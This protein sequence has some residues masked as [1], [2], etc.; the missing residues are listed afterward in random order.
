METGV[1]AI[2]LIREASQ[3]GPATRCVDAP[4]FSR[5]DAAISRRVSET[6]RTRF[7]VPP[8]VVRKT[9]DLRLFQKT[10]ELSSTTGNP[11]V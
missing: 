6:R 4:D 5:G 1:E 10:I 7:S 9:V 2:A 3:T 11:G 8:G